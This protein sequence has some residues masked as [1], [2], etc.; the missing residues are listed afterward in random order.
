MLLL[1][2]KIFIFVSL[3][4]IRRRRQR[5][6][7]SSIENRPIFS[8]KINIVVYFSLQQQKELG[9]L[10]VLKNRSNMLILTS[11]KCALK[12]EW[13][14]TVV[15]YDAN[16]SLLSITFFRGHK[17][18]IL[19]VKTPTE[20]YELGKHFLKAAWDIRILWIFSVSKGGGHAQE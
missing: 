16:W 2:V 3:N 9:K 17:V 7:K 10:Y 11:F 4:V 12:V 19:S 5:I 20:K 14:S 1:L 18:R 15:L 8:Q 13:D 6:A